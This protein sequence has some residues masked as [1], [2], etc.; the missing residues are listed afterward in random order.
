MSCRCSNRGPPPA[1]AD[2]FRVLFA[3]L[4]GT[5]QLRAYLA[6]LQTVEGI[7]GLLG[8]V[9]VEPGQEFVD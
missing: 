2:G 3:Q 9:G 4:D 5:S 6:L 8:S 7:D 1:G